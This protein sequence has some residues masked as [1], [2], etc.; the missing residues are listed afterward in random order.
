LVSRC[1]PVRFRPLDDEEMRSILERH[2]VP[3]DV[4]LRLIELARGSPGRALHE[5]RQ[6]QIQAVR[7]AEELWQR[8]PGQ[9][10]GDI[11]RSL[12][13]RGRARTTRAEAEERVTA[14]LVPAVR[15]LR[16]PQT[17]GGRAEA[18]HRLELLQAALTQLRRNVSPGLV[19]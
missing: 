2:G 7:E 4:Q 9:K 12:E 3:E 8:L 17:S 11:V 13:G 10:P 5:N 16:S 15:D 18:A 6:E 19:L 1:Q 14:L